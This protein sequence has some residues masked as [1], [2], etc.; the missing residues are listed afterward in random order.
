MNSG[1]D[2]YADIGADHGD[3]GEHP[4]WTAADAVCEEG[5]SNGDKEVPDLEAA[6]DAGLLV[7]ARDIEVSEE[8]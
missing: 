2:G 4:E 8:R 1:G 5:A 6:V 3:Q 7:G